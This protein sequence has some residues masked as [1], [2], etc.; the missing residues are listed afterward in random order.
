MIAVAVAPDIDY[1]VSV[2]E[3]LAGLPSLRAEWQAL[4]G[5]R[6]NEPSTS[7]E[8]T[9]AMARHHQRS[10]D[11]RFLVRVDRGGSLAA[12]VPLVLR[13]F[14]VMGQ[15]IALLT[16]LSE[17]NNTHS[18]LL[19]AS[20]DD[21]LVGAVVSGVLSLG[22]RWDCFR[23]ARVLEGNPL[24]SSFQ[25]ALTHRKTP[26]LVRPGLPAYVL[27]L[28]SS[29]AAYLAARS[30][31]FRNHLKRTEKKLSAIGR[32]EFHQLG[33]AGGFEAAFD[34]L[35]QIE[36]NSWKQSFGSAIT[37]VDHQAGFYRDFAQAALQDGSLHLQWLTIDGKP[38]AYNLGCLTRA[39]Y[40]YLKTSYDHAYRPFGPATVL[41][42]RLIESLIANGV[43]RVDFPGEPYAWESQW[44]TTTRTRVALTVYPATV[45]GRLLRSA[46]RLRHYNDGTAK[47]EHVDPRGRRHLTHP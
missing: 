45:R 24:L 27:D 33:D 44:T 46:D 42:A 35:M 43:P 14:T 10:G 13:R 7:F 9:S 34:A 12:I 2:I 15:A 38:V 29:Y 5:S 30:A 4:F 26:F 39:G 28:P 37:A 31:K 8:W 16:P 11:R 41:R 3:D 23:M 18:D 25:R 17:E 6:Q 32:P 22:A 1:S 19:L 36:R 40:H 20:H 47:V 21:D